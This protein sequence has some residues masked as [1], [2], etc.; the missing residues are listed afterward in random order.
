MTTLFN[1][2]DCEVL[3]ERSHDG[4]Q[5]RTRL[6]PDTLFKMEAIYE[7]LSGNKSRILRAVDWWSNW[8]T[9]D[10]LPRDFQFI[11]SSLD[12]PS[13]FVMLNHIGEAL[14]S[15]HGKRLSNIP[16]WSHAFYCV[17]EYNEC[18][19]SALPS[20]H[21]IEQ[22]FDKFSREYVRFMAPIQNERGDVVLIV[23]AYRHLQLTRA[24]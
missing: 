8:R 21:Y 10:D 20:A 17:D 1:T 19:K 24:E 15:M 7:R 11:D 16:V 18:R 13:H 23:Y 14:G 22:S 4:W 6:S 2:Q 5:R 9:A 12:D 3:E